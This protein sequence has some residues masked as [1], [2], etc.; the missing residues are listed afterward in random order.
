V[1]VGEPT[2]QARE[3]RRALWKNQRKGMSQRWMALPIDKWTR[4]DS[5][6]KGWGLLL[7]GDL[8]GLITTGKVEPSPW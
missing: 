5:C 8:R 1:P 2:P 7:I 6:S 4:E 3:C